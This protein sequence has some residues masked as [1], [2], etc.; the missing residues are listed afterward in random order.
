MKL[1]DLLVRELPKRGGWPEGA[2]GAVQDALGA[3]IYFFSGRAPKFDGKAWWGAKEWITTCCPNN[4]LCEDLHS[5]IVTFQQYEAALAASKQVEWSGE[6]LPPEGIVCEVKS[7]KDSWALCKVV[8]S[9]EAGVAF[10]YLEERSPYS[11]CSYLGVIDCIARKYADGY[12]RP[13]RTEAE[14]KR[15]E[16]IDYI[17]SLIGRGTFSQD[18]E[19][20][21]DAIA[22]GKIPVI[23]LE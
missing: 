15:E 22:A 19:S 20:I 18:A 17:A 4:E 13:I 14:R 12:F 5:S 23:R 7:G 10:I 8:H 16:A 2:E 6:W 1:I 21:Y 9:S 11:L 3:K